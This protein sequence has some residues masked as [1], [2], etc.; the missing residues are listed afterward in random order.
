MEFALGH[1]LNEG[2][3]DERGRFGDV[4]QSG[5]RA[6]VGGDGAGMDAVDLG[7]LAG[8]GFAQGLGQRIR[9]RLRGGV[10]G[11]IREA[12]QGND[13]VH[14]GE[15][16][17]SVRLQH[18]SKGPGDAEEA[19]DV[20]LHLV[21]ERVEDGVIEGTGRRQD[22]AVVHDDRHIRGGRSGGEDGIGIR[23]IEPQRH[24]PLAV[25]RHEGLRALRIADGGV[26]LPGAV[27]QEGFDEGLADAPVGSGDEG[28]L[29]LEGGG[30]G[31]E[32]LVGEMG[33]WR[34][35]ELTGGVGR[36]GKGGDG[37]PIAWEIGN[38][39][40]PHFFCSVTP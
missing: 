4:L 25:S 11:E 7:A 2:F 6:H 14:L 22:A 5:S 9:R 26:D 3:A 8:E 20:H 12:L 13:G 30:H 35:G 17:A 33:R 15:G 28:G 23:E 16:A 1:R 19:A 37:R 27:L 24:D 38:R 34:C 21:F 18:R 10:G 36:S 32:V 39:S 31:G 40:R 29:V